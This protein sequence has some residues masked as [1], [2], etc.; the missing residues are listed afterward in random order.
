MDQL[1]ASLGESDKSFYDSQYKNIYTR[2]YGQGMDPFEGYRY[3]FAGRN[4]RGN[5]IWSTIKGGLM[6]IFKSLLPYLGTSAV[7]A[8]G[9]LIGEMKSG[10]KFKDALKAQSRRSGSKIAQDLSDHLAQEGGGRARRRRRKGK[11][12][13][14]RSKKTKMTPT[15]IKMKKKRKIIRRSR[16]RKTKKGLLFA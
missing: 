7:D 16:R 1:L 2:Q 4:L 13:G 8:M 11:R 9:G 6:P 3:Q 10:K 14:K 5:G 12:K 15:L